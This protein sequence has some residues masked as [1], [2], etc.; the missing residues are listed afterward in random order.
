MVAQGVFT[1]GNLESYCNVSE[2]LALLEGYDL[3][4]W[5][6]ADALQR[7]AQQLVGPTKAAID[8]AA[9]RDFML[10]VDETV[11][12]DGTGQSKLLLS[13]LGLVPVVQVKAVRVAGAELP[14]EAW[15]LYPEEAYVALVGGNGQPSRFPVGK[16]NVEVTMD[17]GYNTPPADI[18][19][20]QAKLIAAELLSEIS[21]ERGGVEAVRLGDYTVRYGTAGHYAQMI[22]RLVEEATE[23][24][25]RYR[26]LDFCVI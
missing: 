15:L 22:R 16:R 20:A 25:S 7:R 11:V 4:G 3:S 13:P 6:D 2:A 18:A 10:H 1:T 12:V 24:V 5:G 14:P 9:G 21:G 19:L 26:Q 23:T 8:T 17:W